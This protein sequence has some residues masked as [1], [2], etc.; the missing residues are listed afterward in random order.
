MNMEL[1]YGFVPKAGS[2]DAMIE[3]KANELA[4]KIVLRTSNTMKLEDQEN[5][6]E[7]VEKAIN[8]RTEELKKEMPKILW[9]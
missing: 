1:V 3:E 2:L 5:F 6:K 4:T 9:D 8:E 7:R